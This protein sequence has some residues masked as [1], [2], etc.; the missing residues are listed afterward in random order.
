MQAT[1]TRSRPS[2][3][4]SVRVK[5]DRRQAQGSP[6]SLPSSNT[7]TP[8]PVPPP[9]P[10]HNPPSDDDLIEVPYKPKSPEIIDLDLYESPESPQT[11]SKRKKLDILKRGGLEVTAVRGWPG[12]DP[13]FQQQILNQAHFLQVYGTFATNAESYAPPPVTQAKSIYGT[14]SPEKTVY[15]NPKDPFMPPPHVLQGAAP[16]KLPCAQRT[17]TAADVLDLT[18][19]PSVEIV[20]VPGAPEQPQNLSARRTS[21]PELRQ[22]NSALEITLVN[23]N[24]SRH[25]NSNS[26]SNSNNS[27]NINRTPQKRSSTGK[28]MSNKGG[29]YAN[30]NNHHNS[31][32]PPLVPRSL[33]NKSAN[34]GL[35][36]PNYQVSSSSSVSPVSSGGGGNMASLLQGAGGSVAPGGRAPLLDP[37]LYMSALYGS[38]GHLAPGISDRQLALYSQLV[39]LGGYQVPTSKN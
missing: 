12:L 34:S 36:I 5:P 28:F 19:K 1:P 6:P 22:V 24:H 35:V 30:H 13:A 18:V 32:I 3:L 31:T 11:A 14:S 9:P 33:P 29:I 25:N 17:A 20:R 10:L 7:P 16:R 21:T 15:G 38:L 37:S 4:R 8:T 27:N 23:K 26:G 39:K 2:S